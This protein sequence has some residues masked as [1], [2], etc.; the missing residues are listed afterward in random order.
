MTQHAFVASA[1]H[2]EVGQIFLGRDVD[3]VM[4]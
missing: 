1:T 3:T 2:E 4:R